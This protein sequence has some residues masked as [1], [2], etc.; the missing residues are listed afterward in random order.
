M[1][2]PVTVEQRARTFSE[3]L[4]DLG[5]DGPSKLYVGEMVHAFGERAFGAVMLVV[6][7]LNLLPWPPGGTT[8]MGAPLLLLSLELAWGRDELW[9]PQWALKGSVSRAG[10]RRGLARLLPTIRFAERWT[11]P[12]L[13]WLT[14]S[15]G[16]GLI[17]L[18]CLFLSVVLVLPIPLGN[19]APAAAIALFSL[20]VMQRDG[21]AVILGWIAAT[22][23]VGLLALVWATVWAVAS[24]LLEHAGGWF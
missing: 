22:V 5:R 13:C 24:R 12:R 11:R 9:L 21:I 3:V 8:L 23:S 16:Q 1:T 2:L 18:A 6:A 14:S 10:Y 15:L 7:L 20:G 17:G 19:I 4:E